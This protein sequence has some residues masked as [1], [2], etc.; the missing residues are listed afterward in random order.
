MI[1]VQLIHCGVPVT[2]YDP[3]DQC[4]K[5]LISTIPNEQLGVARFRDYQRNLSK[6]PKGTDQLIWL[7]SIGDHFHWLQHSEPA[8]DKWKLR[9]VLVFLEASVPLSR[10]GDDDSVFKNVIRLGRKM[11]IRSPERP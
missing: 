4:A 11:G 8:L 5:P 10:G 1:T 7:E 6:G 9:R 3:L 2:I